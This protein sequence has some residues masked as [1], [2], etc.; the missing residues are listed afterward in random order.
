MNKMVKQQGFTLIELISVIVILGI[1]AATAVPRFLD[2]SDAAE[3]AGAKGLAGSLNSS[4]AVNFAAY[5]ACDAGLAGADVNAIVNTR[6]SSCLAAAQQFANIDVGVYTVA[7]ATGSSWANA[8]GS[9]NDCTVAVDLNND[10]DSTDAN[11]VFPFT[12]FAVQA[13]ANCN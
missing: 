8:N 6:R 7:S 1:L 13:P 5:T 9:R 11:E 4:S 2:L 3:E 10:N 12:M